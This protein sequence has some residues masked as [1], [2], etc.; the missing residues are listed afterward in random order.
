MTKITTKL[1]KMASKCLQDGFLCVGSR[2]ITQ[3]YVKYHKNIDIFNTFLE[4][5]KRPKA[6]NR[7]R[8]R[9]RRIKYNVFRGRPSPKS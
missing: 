4:V 6:S 7:I 2:R 5:R 9:S 3:K 8:L 1:I